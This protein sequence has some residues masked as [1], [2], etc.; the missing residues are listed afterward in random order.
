MKESESTV[1]DGFKAVEFV[2]E[3]RRQIDKETKGMNFEEFKEYLK[4][5][6]EKFANAAKESSEI[7]AN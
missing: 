3:V 2:R 4:N 5:R 1:I 7:L 6:R